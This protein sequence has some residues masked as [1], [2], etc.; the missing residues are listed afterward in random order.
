MTTI[1]WCKL[2]HDFADDTKFLRVADLTGATVELVQACFARAI[3][4]G[5]AGPGV[6]AGRR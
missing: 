2:H 4:R 3:C 5:S 6:D 1:T